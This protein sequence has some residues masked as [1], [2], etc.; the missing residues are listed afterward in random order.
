MHITRKVKSMNRRSTGPNESRR[1]YSCM[2][3]RTVFRASAREV[4]L[5]GVSGAVSE[6]LAGVV[7]GGQA[8]TIQALR[9]II[10]G[11]IFDLRRRWMPFPCGLPWGQERLQLCDRC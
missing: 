2:T 3:T 4:C 10:F 5:A 11:V 7:I 6:G 1:R 9:H 8:Y